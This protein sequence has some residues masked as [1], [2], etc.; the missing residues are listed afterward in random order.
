MVQADVD[1]YV[2]ATIAER[3]R[4]DDARDLLAAAVGSVDTGPLEDR[5]ATL[6]ARL[7]GLAAAYAVGD[8]DAQQL[9][10]GSRALRAD[11]DAVR[12]QIAAA[13]RGS[14]LEGITDAPDPGAAFLDADVER[15]QA[16]VA[17]LASVTLLPGSRG[18]PAGW[19]PGQ[20]Y[21]RPERVEITWRQS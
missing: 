6:R 12:E 4:R 13:T 18:R 3:L 5:A 14:A 2:T 16:V 21:F 17:L 15:Q 1:G 19:Q 20:S 10:E 11:L 9:A 8:I 7:D